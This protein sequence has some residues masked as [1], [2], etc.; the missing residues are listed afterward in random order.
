MVHGRARLD[1]AAVVAHQ[2]L[3]GMILRIK[4]AMRSD[5]ATTVSR[6]SHTVGRYVSTIWWHLSCKRRTRSGA[7]VCTVGL[8]VS[9]F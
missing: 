3:P 2:K 6:A 4:R 8:S 7:R 1:G 9:S 5:A